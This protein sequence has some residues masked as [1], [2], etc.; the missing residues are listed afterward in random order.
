MPKQGRVRAKQMM[1]E[2]AKG[3]CRQVQSRQSDGQVETPWARASRIEIE[4]PA[5][6]LDPG[7]MR[8]AEN[9]HVDPARD[10]IELH[11]LNVVQNVN[12]AP[13][14]RHHPRLRIVFRPMAGIDVPLDRD[15]RRNPVK[16]GDNVWRTD[17]AGMDDMRDAREILLNLR[18]QEPVSV[19]DDSNSEHC[20]DVLGSPNA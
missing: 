2:R 14:E 1:D 8:V 12:A 16:S 5:D 20:G 13:A 15:D 9:D 7:P 18:T 19:R 17:I 3:A 11:C 10:R 4:H 6:S